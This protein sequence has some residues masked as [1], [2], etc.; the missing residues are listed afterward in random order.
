[1]A[2]N[3]RERKSSFSLFGFFKG[4]SSRV[5]RGGDAARDEHMKPY[6]VYPSDEDRGRW[7]SEPG[8]DKKASA[9][10]SLT[11]DKWEKS[12]LAN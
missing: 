12:A 10:I 9:Y 6:K 1:M 7:F 8:I 11:T 4:K 2:G 3:N 5:R